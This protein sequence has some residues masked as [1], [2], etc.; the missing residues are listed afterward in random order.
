MLLN[1]ILSQIQ[2]TK[3]FE[4]NILDIYAYNKSIYSHKLQILTTNFILESFEN[5]ILE[6]CVHASKY[7]D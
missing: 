3:S 2:H 4:N 1:Q 7:M 6:S 5:N